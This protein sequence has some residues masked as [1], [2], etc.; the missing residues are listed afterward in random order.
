MRNK[1]KLISVVVPVYNGGHTVAE[2]VERIITT[3]DEEYDS[4]ELI[5]VNDGSSDNS[6]QL[7]TDLSH[8]HNGVVCGLNLMRNY[9]QHNALLAGI[10]SC[11]GDVIVTIDDDLQHMPEDIPLLLNQLYKGNDVV[12]GVPKKLNNS[13]FRNITSSFIKSVLIK[14]LGIKHAGETNSFRVFDSKLREAFSEFKSPQVSIDVMLTWGAKNIDSIG[15]HHK[16]RSLG[17]SGYSIKKLLKYA[18]TMI[19][20]FSTLPLRIASYI[21]FV[22]MLLGFCIFAYVSVRYFVNSENVP[23]FAFLSSIIAIFSGVQLFSLGVIG[24]YLASVHLR[25]LNMPTYVIEEKVFKE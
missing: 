16:E 14:S 13:L 5:L 7:I 21:G 20:G 19:T 12:Y 18:V 2:L 17:S 11:N 15:I 24:E 9:G 3:L 10:R 22:F 23:G 1:A 6:W 8:K 25:A 4:Y